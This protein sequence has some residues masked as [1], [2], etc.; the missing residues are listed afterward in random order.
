MTYRYAVIGAGRQGTAAAYDLGKHGEAEYILM[1]DLDASRAR[2]SADRINQLL[3][4]DI[5]QSAAVDASDVAAVTQ[6]LLDHR[7]DALIGASVY[8]HNFG[9][10]QAAIAAGAGMT[11]LGGN[12]D[13]V[14][15]QM[16]LSEEA[17]AKGL[18][19]VPDCGQV[20]GMGTT[21]ILYGMEQLDDPQDAYM[22]DCG[23]PQ[24]PEEPWNYR[25]TFNIEG[26]TNEYYGDCLF[27]R[28]GKTVGIP[29][30][31]EFEVLEFPAPIGKLEA[32]TTS[33]GLTTAARTF[34]GKLRTLQN[35]TMRYPG[36]FAQLK[37][38]ET[39]GLLDLDPVD[40]NGTSVVP[41]EVLHKL[42]DPQIKAEG[43][44][45]DLVLVHILVQGMKDGQKTDVRVEF[46]HYFDED[47]GFTAMEQGT[48]W[49]AA[50][51]T[52]AI[53]RGQTPKG[54][55]A[56]EDAISGTEFVKQAA[57]RDFKVSLD[58][59]QAD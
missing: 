21:L 5:S 51:V 47:T 28:E 39:L 10:T 58:V 26:L 36:N 40:I 53:A 8:F 9:L 12:S 31:R 3:G 50:I 34:E 6:L 55:I 35:K 25:L 13:V 48:G 37:T 33:G 52:A 19:I 4:E 38:I 15:Q 18:S 43:E 11:D 56:I 24:H 23:L 44:V 20:P 1:A 30:L 14:F 27:I 49:H 16:E 59:R 29:A 46:L 7:I 45:K 17:A 42:W 54:V 2:K 41:R 32:F 57:L 22:W